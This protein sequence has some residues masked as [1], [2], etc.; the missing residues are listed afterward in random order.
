VV[1]LVDI[2][3]S[4][5]LSAVD[6]LGV[7]E[8]QLGSLEG[9]GLLEWVAVAVLWS[10]LSEED[11]IVFGILDIRGE[12]VDA[13]APASVLEVVVD[14][15]EEDLLNW[16]LEEIFD[17]FSWFQKAVELWVVNQI[18]LGEK[19]NSDDLPD[20]TED[21]VSLSIDKI[22]SPDVDDV[23]T[24]TLG[25]VDA[26]GLVLDNTE[27]VKVLLVNHAF[28]NSVWNSIIDKF[29]KNETILNSGEKAH[30]LCVDWKMGL[31]NISILLKSIV[32]VISKS[33]L[34]F[35][36]ERVGGGVCSTSN[37][38]NVL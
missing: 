30:I 2:L 26:K 21:Q 38:M 31:A 29:A 24:D 25:G 1:T 32:D 23:A 37:L 28:I 22:L 10:N 6:F 27:S 8:D 11:C 17:G 15:S 13:A 36:G 7:L 14:P 20:E 19:T 18:D 3:G 9:I 16:E 34:L 12:V 4:N 33:D 5:E 35:V